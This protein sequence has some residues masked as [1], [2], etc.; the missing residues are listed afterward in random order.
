[1]SRR[2][3]IFRQR[4]VTR[5]VKAVAAAGV[6]VAKVE[7]HVDGKIVVVMAGPSETPRRELGDPLDE[8]MAKHAHSTE[9]H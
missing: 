5:A 7:M 2:P 9:G 1:V 8:W 3:F 6:L 4:D